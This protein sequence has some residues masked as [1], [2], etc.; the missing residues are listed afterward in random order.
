[1][2]S[3]L[4]KKSKI[5]NCI[6]YLLKEIIKKLILINFNYFI[7][8]LIIEYILT[9]GIDLT[10]DT[11]NFSCSY[12]SWHNIRAELIEATFAYLEDLIANQTKGIDEERLEYSVIGHL[13]QY[14]TEIREE[15]A[16]F[17]NDKPP[18]SPFALLFS[19]RTI[20]NAF[21]EHLGDLCFINILIQFGVGGIYTLCNKSDCDGFYSVGNSYDICEL[22]NVIK[23]FTIKNKDNLD[24]EE[25][26]IYR[27]T[28]KLI[29]LFQESLDKKL[30]VYIS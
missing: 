27:C 29:E 11:K 26:Y 25:N 8:K 2:V 16:S 23:P 4:G 28:D 19:K 20:F 14:I 6:K 1:M 18:I 24:D 10:C 21:S 12:S 30:I 17:E 5:F 22:L 7:L 9:M 15:C 3:V 13:K